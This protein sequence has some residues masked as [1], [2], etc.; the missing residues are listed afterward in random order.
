MSGNLYALQSIRLHIP[1]LTM[2][3]KTHLSYK[4][5]FACFV[6]VIVSILAVIATFNTIID[7][8]GIFRVNKSLQFAASSLLDGKMV[9]GSLGRYDERELQRLIVDAHPRR[10]V[11]ILGSSRTMPLRKSF[12]DPSLDVFNHSL[13]GAGLEDYIALIDLYREKGSFPKTIILAIDPWMFNKNNGLLDAWKALDKQYR[14]MWFELFSRRDQS[15]FLSLVTRLKE[16][17]NQWSQLINLAYTMQNWDSVMNSSRLYARKAVRITDTFE[18]D[19]FVREPDGS[20]YFP[21]IMRHVKQTVT[22]KDNTP[23]ITIKYFNNFTAL[24]RTD[25]FEKLVDY[26][27]AHGVRVVF[28]IPPFH[29]CL[30]R[31]CHEDAGYGMALKVEEYLAVLAK[32]QNITVIGTLDPDR[33]GFKGEDF[34]DWFHG[35]DQ[36]M[37]RLFTGYK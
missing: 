25:V 10:D 16:K 33:Y 15:E 6:T 31:L 28:L 27:Q 11:I 4:R 34:F 1:V 22:G 37:K 20:V 35:H 24:Y 29:P 26:L 7:G 18:I 13:S 19:D 14:A 21:Y 23:R 9:A 17:G 8:V 30:Y 3:K 5:W 12:I 36:V 32:K 2:T